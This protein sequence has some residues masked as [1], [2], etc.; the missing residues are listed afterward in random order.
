MKTDT[1]ANAGVRVESFRSTIIPSPQAGMI[2]MT[3]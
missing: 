3:T 1:I 2:R